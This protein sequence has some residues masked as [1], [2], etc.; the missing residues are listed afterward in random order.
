MNLSI[1][2]SPSA[3][4]KNKASETEAQ[5]KKSSQEIERRDVFARIEQ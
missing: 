2:A 5:T 4:K 3:P 1:K